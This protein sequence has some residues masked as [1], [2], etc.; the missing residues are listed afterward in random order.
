MRVEKG[1]EPSSVCGTSEG[2]S[3]LIFQHSQRM[4]KHRTDFDLELSRRIPRF[5]KVSLC[6]SH[7]RDIE[8]DAAQDESAILERTISTPSGA[9]IEDYHP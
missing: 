4:V 1:M 8:K 5:Q 7:V 3:F 2:V 9:Y 6:A